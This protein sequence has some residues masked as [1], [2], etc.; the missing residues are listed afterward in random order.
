MDKGGIMKSKFS[1][2][3]RY[4]ALSILSKHIGKH[5]A[6]SMPVLYEKVFEERP[7]TVISGTR[8]LRTLITELRNQ[9]EPICSS[10][11]GGYYLAA[12]GSELNDYCDRMEHQAIRKLR[13]VSKIKKM[14]VQELCNQLNIDFDAEPAVVGS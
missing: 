10:T 12:V 2:T 7:E 3:E 5:N 14:T 4:K 1:D 8:K 11:D 9:G 6:I 13:I